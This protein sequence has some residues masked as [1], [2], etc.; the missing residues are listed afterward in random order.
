MIA[1][2]HLVLV[3]IAFAAD[4]G[5]GE[6][7]DGCC[8]STSDDETVLLPFAHACMADSDCNGGLHCLPTPQ[9]LDAACMV[10]GAP[11]AGPDAS[12]DGGANTTYSGVA[13]TCTQTCL[14]DM[15]CREFSEYSMPYCST[16]SSP[17]PAGTADAGTMIR[18]CSHY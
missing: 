10:V 8:D 11:D 3:A 4:I 18:V 16:C 9:I 12:A 1:A 14:V 17:A 7:N 15:D 13:M 2:R 5:S 6:P